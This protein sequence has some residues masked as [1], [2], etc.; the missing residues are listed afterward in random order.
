MCGV[1]VPF[2][3][4]CVSIAGHERLDMKTVEIR[5]RKLKLESR[6]NP[7]SSTEPSDSNRFFGAVA[8]RI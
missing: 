1:P 5:L 6:D 2:I 4:S 8:P 3:L 7:L